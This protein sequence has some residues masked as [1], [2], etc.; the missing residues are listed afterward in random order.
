MNNSQMLSA[1]INL[2]KP[3]KHRNKN[4]IILLLLT[5][6]L[7]LPG[8]IL[9]AFNKFLHHEHSLGMNFELIAFL[10]GVFLLL[11]ITFWSKHKGSFDIFE[12]PTWFSMN[13]YV[14]VILNTWLLQRDIKPSIPFLAFNF[15]DVMTNGS[16]LFFLGIVVLWITYIV[17]FVFFERRNFHKER[18]IIRHK[19][20]VNFALTIWII[21]LGIWIF[22]VWSGVT[23]YLNTGF[24]F[25]STFANYFHFFLL[26]NLVVTSMLAIYY[27]QNQRKFGKYWLI[28]MVV[29]N[30][31]VSLIIGTKSFVFTFIWIVLFYF[32]SKGRIPKRWIFTSFLLMVILVPII[33]NYRNYLYY[34]NTGRGV[35]IEQRMIALEKA[36]VQSINQPFSSSLDDTRE[37]IEK[38][39]GGILETTASVIFLHPKYISFVGDEMVNYIVPQ[40]IP[41]TFWPNKPII[42][43]D[44]HNITTIYRGASTEYTF[45]TI[46]LFADSYRAGGLIV[47]GLW[48]A[49][50]GIFFSWVYFRAFYFRNY[51]FKIFYVYLLVSNIFTYESDMSTTLIRLI[52]FS[53]IIIMIIIFLLPENKSKQI[54]KYT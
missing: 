43:N 41:R 12:F 8:L 24:G 5:I 36:I 50:L 30:I 19:F 34:A 48:F 11:I 20:R 54:N 18:K 23:G 1:K 38:R 4:K 49:L 40:L 42:R 33:N 9:L 22:S 25:L 45:S 26:I 16:L 14:L 32:Y 53:P 3:N 17:F 51:R 52:Q 13:A 31:V 2:I 28:L 37:V 27:L 29:I 47:T 46:G 6:I 10:M 7:L 21:T 44:L 39:Q 35:S 15:D